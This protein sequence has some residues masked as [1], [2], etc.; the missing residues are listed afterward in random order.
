MHKIYTRF[1]IFKDICLV[2]YS[3]LYVHILLLKKLKLL[4]KSY[5]CINCDVEF[6]KYFC[7]VCR[8]YDGSET[9]KYHC[10]GCGICRLG[11]R[12]N[13]FHCDKCGYCLPTSLISG[14]R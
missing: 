8:L 9:E 12:E 3:S 4:I 11:K 13:Y 7:S 5:R 2:F 10:S 6:G 1:Y 14:H